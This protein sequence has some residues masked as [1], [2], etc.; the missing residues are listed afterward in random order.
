[1]I[2]LGERLKMLCLNEGTTP[3]ELE[4]LIGASKG[5]ISRA[6]SRGTNVNS[7]WLIAIAEHYPEWSVE[8]LLTGKGKS[9]KNEHENDLIF[10][11]AYTKAKEELAPE[12][13]YTEGVPYY[14]EMFECGFNE[15]V[16]PGSENP[17]YLIKM[18]GYEKA[19]HLRNSSGHSME[20]EINNGDIIAMRR[21]EDFSFLTF[22]DIYGIITTN[23]LRTIKRIGRSAD[24]KCYRLIPT[25][26]EYDE[27]DIP[28]D[29]ILIVYRV[30]G[31]M[32]SF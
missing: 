29:M 8:W 4:R 22:G 16:A 14:D 28:K 1:M 30:M 12:I 3:T 6:V 10:E 5:V 7:K 32:K 11:A 26:K 19:T 9:L 13:S 17:E 18:P 27:Q 2:N 24:P 31:A 25:N 23:G 15:L 20:P 21:I